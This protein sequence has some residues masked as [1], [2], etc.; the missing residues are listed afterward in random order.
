MQL[1]S[2]YW[3]NH[4]NRQPRNENLQKSAK[5]RVSNEMKTLQCKVCNYS[6]QCVSLLLLIVNIFNRNNNSSVMEM[7]LIEIFLFI[8]CE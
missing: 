2:L 6:Y 3:L 1:F 5:N 4:L 7:A 8:L